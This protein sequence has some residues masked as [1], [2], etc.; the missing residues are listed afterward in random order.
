M[1]ARVG[2][3]QSQLPVMAAIQETPTSRARVTPF[4]QPSRLSRRWT[5]ISAHPI[6]TTTIAASTDQM[7]M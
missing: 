6:S 4:A 5:A 7:V 1:P 2:R 3:T